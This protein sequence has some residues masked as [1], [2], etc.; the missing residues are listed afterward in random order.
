MRRLLPIST[1]LVV[2]MLMGAACGGDSGPKP[3]AVLASATTK[4]IDADSSRVAL[5]ID[6]TGADTGGPRQITGEGAFDYGTRHGT[7]TMDA[8]ALGMPGLTGTIE[9][10][11]LG[12]V[13][14]MK[15]PP[16]ILPGKP[17]LKIDL[18]T[19]GEAS[20]ANLAG[21]QEL[22]S[23]DPSANL[24]FLLGARDDA[25]ERGKAEVR[26]VETTQY[27]FTVDLEKAK[28][29]IPADLRDDIDRLIEQIGRSTYPAD[30]W[31]DGDGLIRRLRFSF[32]G[33]GGG[34]T[35]DVGAV[36]SQEFFD[37]G[38]KVEAAP[39]P[40][41]QVSDFAQILQQAGQG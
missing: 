10:V 6:I 39:P 15:F 28:A 5:T 7:M 38:V 35:G 3:V 21:L 32:S 18:Q 31:I 27:H 13:F 29:D 24:R 23:N 12:D 4:T 14:F 40:E 41:D 2:A 1:A 30:A 9:M 8:G 22:S 16:G 19:L 34:A 37:F 25:E 11:S 26:G 33:A 36:V 17:W 20:G